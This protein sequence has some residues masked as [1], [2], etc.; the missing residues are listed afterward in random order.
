MPIEGLRHLYGLVSNPDTK[1][2]KLKSFESLIFG[3]FLYK[4]S[5]KI[6][7]TDINSYAKNNGLK[8]PSQLILSKVIEK[9]TESGVIKKDDDKTIALA[10]KES[11]SRFSK[12]LNENQEKMKKFYDV[13]ISKM[14]NHFEEVFSQEINDGLKRLISYVIE[15]VM[16]NYSDSVIAFY[17]GELK[18]T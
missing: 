6:T 16:E 5:L 10:E 14:Q 3:T 9:L 7:I 4:N 13:M 12:Q 2:M 1:D 15:E 17:N 8:N 18:W 11:F